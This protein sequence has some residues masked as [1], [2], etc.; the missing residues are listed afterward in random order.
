MTRISIVA[1]IKKF[2]L[3]IAVILIV[4]YSLFPFYWMIVSSLKTKQ[5]LFAR[6]PTLIPVDITFENFINLFTKTSAAI[7]LLNSI[8]TAFVSI[9]VS[10][11]LA[12][13]AAYALTR[14][15]FRG[16]RLI[17][18]SILFV[19]M[20]PPIMVAIP[21][22]F[23]ICKINMLD[24]RIGL[25]LTY[26]AKVMP[27]TIWLLIAFFQTIPVEIEES[28]YVDGATKIQTLRRVVLPL[29]LPGIIST[30]LFGLMVCWNEYVFA[31]TFLS[32]ETKK[33]IPVGL[34]MFM[35]SH[36]VLWEY[37]FALSIVATI[38]VLLYF[39]RQQKKL[40]E[41]MA[42]GVKA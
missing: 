23:L 33:T 9:F 34:R 21:L 4:V 15:R 11:F 16:R 28:A 41:T 35:T 5:E 8:V 3:Y 42:G 22:F 17:T 18:N 25:V 29:A 31:L 24:T 37:I 38:P 27:Y 14:F 26:S 7:W 12:S 32:S 40:L 13:L 30:S 39:I 20:F 19:Y 1:L 36:G 10:V 6:T 2:L